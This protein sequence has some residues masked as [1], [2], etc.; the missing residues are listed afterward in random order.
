MDDSPKVRHC[1]LGMSVRFP[2]LPWCGTAPRG[3]LATWQRL[4][5]PCCVPIAPT[6]ARPQAAGAAGRRVGRADLPRDA[7][8]WHAGRTFRVSVR[9]LVGR[10]LVGRPTRAPAV[11]DLRA[12][13]DGACC[14]RLRELSRSRSAYWRGWRVVALDRTQFSLTNTPQITAAIAKVVAARSWPRGV[15][16]DLDRGAAG[17]RPAQSAGRGHRPPRRVGMDAGAA[18]SRSCPSGPCCRGTGSLWRGG[19]VGPARAAC[20]R[21]GSRF[22]CARAAPPSP[23]S[24]IACAMAPAWSGSHC[25][26]AQPDP[27]TRVARGP[28]DSRARGRRGHRAHQTRLWTSL[29]DPHRAGARTR[30]GLC[31]A[32]GTRAVFRELKPAS[33][34]ASAPESH[35][36]DGGARDRRPRPRQCGPRGRAPSR[37][38]RRDLGCA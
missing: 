22:C 29:L 28:R 31:A 27:D 19:L 20:A 10:Q 8:P 18:C 3:F 7:G 25:A 34:R 36:R 32:L 37:R 11:A 13:C 12:F 1:T 9:R 38:P 14:V 26:P 35:R 15:R 16:E 17:S 6:A 23:A 30:P 24:S 5:G 21:V 33:G 4:V 2:D